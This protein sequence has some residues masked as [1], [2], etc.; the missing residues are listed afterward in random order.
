M[1]TRKID[2]KKKKKKFRKMTT[3]DE[4]SGLN[5]NFN[6]ALKQKV[7]SCD[8]WINSKH[9]TKKNSHHPTI[10]CDC[11]TLEAQFN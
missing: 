3:I 2:Q 6:Y 8:A 11:I 4:V 10:Y 5:G 9:K 7:I 1:L